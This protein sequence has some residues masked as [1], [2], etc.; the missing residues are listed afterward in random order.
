MGFLSLAR[1]FPG[2]AALSAA[3]GKELSLMNS[4]QAGL[5]EKEAKQAAAEKAKAH[6]AEP[7]SSAR[8]GRGRV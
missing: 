6:E 4:H 5:D 1:D 8:A 2:T 3:F 7:H